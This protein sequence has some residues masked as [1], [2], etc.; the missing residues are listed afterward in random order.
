M[1]G[2]Q[3]EIHVAVQYML[4]TQCGIHVAVQYIHAQG[5]KCECWFSD[6]IHLS[7]MQFGITDII[8]FAHYPARMHKGKVIGFVCQHKN[9]QIWRSRHLSDS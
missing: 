8:N 6:L 1:L 4:G 2:T 7:E 9:R 5:P 3:C